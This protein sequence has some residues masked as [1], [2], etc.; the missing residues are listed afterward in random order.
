MSDW[1]ALLIV[2]ALEDIFVG[3]LFLALVLSRDVEQ[4]IAGLAFIGF[5]FVVIRGQM[6]RKEIARDQQTKRD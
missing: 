3:I 5:T 4:I 6:R 2:E 1:I